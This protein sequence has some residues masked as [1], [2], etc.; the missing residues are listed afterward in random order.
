MIVFVNAGGCIYTSKAATY[1]PSAGVVDRLGVR[2]I[3]A[4]GTGK[5]LREILGNSWV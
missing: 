5:T 2:E 1:W 3:E 4:K